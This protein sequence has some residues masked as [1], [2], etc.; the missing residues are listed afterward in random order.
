M[1]QRC[2]PSRCRPVRA[3]QTVCPRPG[4]YCFSAVGR[5][6]RSCHRVL[7]VGLDQRLTTLM[8]L[9]QRAS[10]LACMPPK[11]PLLMH[12]MW[13]PGRAA[14]IDLRHQFVDVVGHLRARRPWG[15][16]PRARPSPGRRR[17]RTP[18]RPLPGSRAAAPSWCPAS[19]CCCAARTPPGCGCLRPDLAAQA[20]ERGADGGRV[21]GKVV[22]DRD[23]PP[24]AHRAAHFHA[25]LDVL[26]ARPARAAAT[27]GATPTCSAAAMAASAL[28]W[29][30]TPVSAHSTRATGWPCCSTSK[31]VRLATRGEVAHRGAKAAHLAP[32]ALVQHARQAFLQP[33]DHDA[34][35]C[36]ARCAPGGG[37]GARWRP[38][39]QR[40]RRGRTPGCS[41]RRC[42]GGSARTCCACRKRRCRIRRLR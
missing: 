39:R 25:A 35:R 3:G 8:F 40:C 38:G 15:P 10:S 22:V 2:H 17:G 20:V 37:T 7:P 9:Q 23:A 6:L 26:E 36:R 21:V 5:S 1:V 41:A 18:G 19:W 12:R 4:R 29:L 30:C 11:P 34:A 14:A 13:S 27:A 32:A 31:V 28:S 16:G 42:A 33:I 24:C